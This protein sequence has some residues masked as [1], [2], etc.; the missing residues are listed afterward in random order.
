[1]QLPRFFRSKQSITTTAIVGVSHGQPARK[2]RN[3]ADYAQ[4]GYQ[5]NVDVYRCVNLVAECMAGIDWILLKPGRTAKDASGVLR[6]K[7]LRARTL[8]DQMRRSKSAEMVEVDSHPLLDLIRQPN[9]SQSNTEF[10]EMYAK[11]MLI[12]GNNFTER[13][14]TGKNDPGQ[15]PL[16]LWHWRPDRTT[17]NV[18]DAQQ[19]VA[20][21][22]YKN[23]GKSSTAP[24]E[25]VMHTRKYHPLNDWYGLSPMES[26]GTNI[27]AANAANEWNLA[28]LMNGGM[29]GGFIQMTDSATEEQVL[30]L[31][32]LRDGMRGPKNAGKIGLVEGGAAFIPAQMT[33]HDMHWLEALKLGTLK[34]C[35][36]FGVSPELIGDQSQKT[37]SN[38]QEARR[39]LYMD[40]VLPEMD[41]LRDALNG[42]LTPL[43]GDDLM[44]DYDRDTIEALHEDRTELFR[45]LEGSSF[46]TV[47]EKRGEVGEEPVDG[48]DVVMV[49]TLSSPL[50]G[51]GDQ[52]DTN[53][54]P[55]VDVEGGEVKAKAWNL[56]TPE[57]KAAHVH[58][59]EHLRGQGESKARPA[60]RERMAREKN[61]VLAAIHGSS[62][63]VTATI[64]AHKAVDHGV[65]AWKD[66]YQRVYLQVGAPVA[67]HV[68]QGL[69]HGPGATRVK[70]TPQDAW[71][72]RV[73]DWL[74]QHG[75]ERVTRVTQTTKD[76]ITASIREGIAE[77]ES[78][79]QIEQRIEKLY[80]EQIIPNRSETIARTETM[81]ASNL[82]SFA[83]ADSTGLNLT[84]Q[85]IA[86]ED[87]RTREDHRRVEPSAKDEPFSVG[88]EQMMFPG[89]DSLGAGPNE[90][91]NCRCVIAFDTAA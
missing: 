69:K 15:A 71:T 66:T 29:P 64:A 33:A 85:W 32:A 54:T 87:A 35:Q 91:V 86:V 49:P 42:W 80:L 70:Q 58:V 19:L 72:K 57:A 73:L 1:M 40:T 10:V 6:A 63:P 62:G 81:T 75:A 25:M 14:G 56:R 21:Y 8:I 65:Q 11:N 55:A 67:A 28:L 30:E 79:Y 38:Y 84:K 41:R 44:L 5:A 68:L 83:A 9:P 23:G 27:D 2:Q 26:I 36:A 60:F 82:A 52:S 53:T 61:A 46:L 50:P 22:T 3:F 12:F 13:V 24:Y 20:S 43:F 78:I 39:A 48:G 51:T 89:D 37:Y 4:D 34:I 17:V 18:G 74:Q 90:I 16:E 76:Q 7:G 77:G 59:V 31:K 88:G 45:R 47:N